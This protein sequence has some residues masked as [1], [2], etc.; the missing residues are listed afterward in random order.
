MIVTIKYNV[1]ECRVCPYVTNDTIEHTCPFTSPSA[2]SEWW[3]TY[4]NGP[5]FVP[6]VYVIHEDCPIKKRRKRSGND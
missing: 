6:N 5:R 2:L 1:E 3:C 4:K